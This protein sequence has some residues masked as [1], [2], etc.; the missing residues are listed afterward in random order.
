MT[1][2]K[3]Q[4]HLK[5]TFSD[6]HRWWRQ[7]IIF[8]QSA[9]PTV[10]RNMFMFRL[11]VY[12]PTV[13]SVVAGDASDCSS[14]FIRVKLQGIFRETSD[15]FPAVFVCRQKRQIFLT[16]GLGHLQLCLWPQTWCFEETSGQPEQAL[17]A[18]TRSFPKP[19]DRVFL[20]LNQSR[21]WAQRGHDI[22]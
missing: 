4:K 17:W 1:Q 10:P 3:S 15:E 12:D 22:K 20:C 21:Q 5:A 14:A 6:K 18:K 11:H 2:T 8:L 13:I 16:R 7:Q 19:P 9:E